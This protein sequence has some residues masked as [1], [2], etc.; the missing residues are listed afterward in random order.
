MLIMAANYFA[1]GMVLATI[2]LRDGRLELAMG[3]H[4]VNNVFLALIANYEGSALPSEPVFTGTELDP[5][6]TLVAIA[7]GGIVFYYWVF[8]REQAQR[9]E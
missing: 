6:F 7:I 2:T 3:L 9:A 4:A 5:W 1:I 8:G